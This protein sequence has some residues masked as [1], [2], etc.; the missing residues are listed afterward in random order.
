V[1]F[2]L[3]SIQSP[4][5]SEIPSLQLGFKITELEKTVG[6]LTQIPGVMSILDP[7]HMPDGKKAVI[8]DPDGHAI[9]LIEY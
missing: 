6:Q 9:E 5:K 2:S 4:K 1:E 3:Y 7:T 8:L